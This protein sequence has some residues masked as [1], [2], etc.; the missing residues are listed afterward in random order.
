MASSPAYLI[1]TER[2]VLRCYSPEL[3]PLRQAAV[4]TTRE[5]L[6]P[7]FTWAKD[8][9]RPVAEH[10]QLVRQLRG[11]FDL[12]QNRIHAVLDAEQRELL[13]ELVLLARGEEK[14]REL[15]YW[16]H[17]GHTGKGVATEMVSA[18]VRVGFELDGLERMDIQVA[19][20]N[21]PSAAVARRL[22]FTLEGT[23]RQRARG[24]GGPAEDTWSFS[25]LA[26]EYPKSP[27]ARV[28]VKAYDFGGVL[29]SGLV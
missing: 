10:L 26:S 4:A 28:P 8:E 5:A 23:L 6:L 3:A 16:V 27:A 2:L 15:G 17:S 13:G 20:G 12:D 25:L 24:D 21:E 9:P 29:L 14:A 19:V 11:K 7:W 1:R 22:G 18:L